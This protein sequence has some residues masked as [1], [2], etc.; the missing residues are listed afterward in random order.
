MNESRPGTNKVCFSNALK[1]ADLKD[2]RLHYMVLTDYVDTR[3]EKVK[4]QMVIS[5]K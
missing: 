2:Q 3:G 5:V 1:R 4:F